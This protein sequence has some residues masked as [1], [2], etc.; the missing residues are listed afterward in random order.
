MS[1]G[2]V[3]VMEVKGAVLMSL[4]AQIPKKHGRAEYERW[5]GKLDPEVA[6]IFRINVSASGWYS[7]QEYLVRPTEIYCDMF[8]NGDEQ[9]SWE[10]GKMSAEYSLHGM[11]KLF[12]QLG[13]VSFILNRAMKILPTFYKPSALRVIEASGT[14]C[15]IRITEFPEL[16]KLMEFRIAGWMEGALNIHGCRNVKIDIPASMPDGQN[17]TEFHITW[18]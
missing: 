6:R 7:L 15:I 1:K 11:Y 13:S 12:M 2:K 18:E 10:L 17:Y 4:K 14:S 3:S 16:N 8:Y 9:G 5:L